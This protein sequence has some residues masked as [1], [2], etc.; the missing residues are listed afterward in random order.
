MFGFAPDPRFPLYP[1][2][3]ESRNTLIAV[4]DIDKQGIVRAGFLPCWI[5]EDSQPE[6]HGHD[7]VGERVV[8]YMRHITQEAGLTANLEWDGDQITF[9][10]R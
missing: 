4:C 9:I 2:H 8:A 1:F 5:N 3:P 10:R 6:V 7:E